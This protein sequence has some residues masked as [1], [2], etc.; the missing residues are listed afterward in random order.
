MQIEF[1]CPACLSKLRVPESSKGQKARC[2]SCQTIVQIPGEPANEMGATRT[3][4]VPSSVPPPQVPVGHLE[5]KS[6]VFSSP[7]IDSGAPKNNLGQSNPYAPTQTHGMGQGYYNADVSGKVL[8]AG[9]VMLI[10]NLFALGVGALMIFG[11][12]A[13]MAENN[14]RDEDY[15]V[16]VCV[17]LCIVGQL[18]SLIGSA[19]MIAKRNRGFCLTAIIL[20]MISGL[21]CCLMPT[22]VGIFPLV[23]LLDFRVKQLME[24]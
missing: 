16:F 1:D 24:K 19:C 13:E 14:V 7:A 22:L 2:P 15:F 21:P 5:P 10:V 3:D 9:I 4:S 23:V 8:A 11:F 18:F 20:G 12:I 6:N 17:M